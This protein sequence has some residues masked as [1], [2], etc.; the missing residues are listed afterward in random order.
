MISL[1][2]FAWKFWI[3]VEFSSKENTCTNKDIRQ[4]STWLLWKV[5]HDKKYYFLLTAMILSYLHLGQST[6][7]LSSSRW[8]V[9]YTSEEDGL[10]NL[11][12]DDENEGMVAVEADLVEGTWGPEVEDG[13]CS[14]SCR[15]VLIE[16]HFRFVN[17]V[18]QLDFIDASEGRKVGAG[19]EQVANS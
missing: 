17:G 15:S 4:Q 13:R 10:G 14:C 6:D 1:T 16:T 5:D 11:I 18:F 7:S 3:F 12:I 8:L 19:L 2:F 9:I